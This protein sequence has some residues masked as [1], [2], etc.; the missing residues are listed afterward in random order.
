MSN[1]TYR[2]N[3]SKT[4]TVNYNPLNGINGTKVFFTVK[5]D[6]YDTSATDATAIIKQD[7]T[8]TANSGVIDL[9]PSTVA[10]TVEPGKYYFDMSVLD[11]AGEIYS[12]DSGVFTLTA[13]TT[14]REA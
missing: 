14:N 12:I 9:N 11:T 3:T 6:K 13:G 5:A 8:L 7:V 10:D 4:L 2:R 1:R